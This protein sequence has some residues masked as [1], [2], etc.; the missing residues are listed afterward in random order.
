MKH[1]FEKWHA[2]KLRNEPIALGAPVQ[3][4][5]F[6][7]Q[8]FPKLRNEAIHE[9]KR[10]GAREKGGKGA[11]SAIF[12][13]RSHAL[14][15]PVQGFEFKVQSYRKIT[16]RTHSVRRRTPCRFLYSSM[17]NRL[18]PIFTKRSHALGAPVQG[19]GFKI[20]SYAKFAKRSQ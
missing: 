20:R 14:D 13:K 8:S 19:F 1:G 6:K 7:V 10:K 16:K 2:R 18:A 15:A 11:V 9:K 3:G 4:F 5:K 17:Q 12:T